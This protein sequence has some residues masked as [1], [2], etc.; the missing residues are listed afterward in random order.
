MAS[1]Y[2]VAWYLAISHFSISSICS[3]FAYQASNTDFHVI[4]SRIEVQRTR[5]FRRDFLRINAKRRWLFRFA[6]FIQIRWDFPNYVNLWFNIIRLLW[7]VL[8]GSLCDCTMISYNEMLA[9]IH[10]SFEQ[11]RYIYIAHTQHRQSTYGRRHPRFDVYWWVYGRE[12]HKTNS[13][14]CF[15]PGGK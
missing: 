5:P 1:I 12:I 4:H 9:S 6:V 13:N 8:Y 2:S 10:I 3:I 14:V 7:Y 11:W 15:F